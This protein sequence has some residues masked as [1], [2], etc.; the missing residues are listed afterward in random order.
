MD[1]RSRRKEISWGASPGVV[2]EERICEMW[3]GRPVR[4]ERTRRCVSDLC[5]V[6]RRYW[7]VGADIFGGVEWAGERRLNVLVAKEKVRF[8]Q[9]LGFLMAGLGTAFGSRS[10]SEANRGRE[11]H[12]DIFHSALLIFI[13]DLLLFVVSRK[14]A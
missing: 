4:V 2:D 13:C 8:C 7:G 6:N 1:S 14:Y 10:F 12:F 11:S 5:V 3:R 9:Q